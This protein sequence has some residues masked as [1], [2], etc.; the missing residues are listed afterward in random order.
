MVRVLRVRGYHLLISR[1]ILRAKR[2]SIL[3]LRLSIGQGNKNSADNLSRYRPT[4]LRTRNKGSSIQAQ[5]QSK[6]RRITRF[7]QSRRTVKSYMCYQ[8]VT[9]RTIR[10]RSS[11]FSFPCHVQVRHVVTHHCTTLISKQTTASHCQGNVI[12]NGR[13]YAFRAATFASMSLT[14]RVSIIHVFIFQG[15]PFF[16]YFTR[17]NKRFKIILNRPRGTFNMFARALNRLITPFP[18]ENKPKPILLE[19]I[20]QCRRAILIVNIHLRIQSVSSINSL[21][22]P[23]FISQGFKKI[24][25]LSVFPILFRRFKYRTLRNNV[26]ITSNPSVLRSKNVIFTIVANQLNRNRTI[27]EVVNR[28]RTMVMKLRNVIFLRHTTIPF[29]AT[30][31][32]MS[33]PNSKLTRLIFPFTPCAREGTNNDSRIAFMNNVRRCEANVFLR[34]PNFTIR[35]ASLFSTII[36]RSCIFVFNVRLTRNRSDSLILLPI[37]RLLRST[38]PSKKFRIMTITTCFRLLK[39]EAMNISVILFR[40]IRGLARRTNHYNANNSINY[41]RSINKGST[42]VTNAFRCCQFFPRPNDQ[43]NYRSPSKI[44]TSSR[45]IMKQLTRD[46]HANRGRKR[47][48]YFLSRGILFAIWCFLNVANVITLRAINVPTRRLFSSAILITT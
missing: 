14:Q 47:C 30:P 15:S 26:H 17:I 21:N 39:T 16:Y 38:Y 40:S 25:N 22:S 7:F 3:R 41:S 34:L 11:F 37:R 18:Q 6:R 10:V 28:A 2:I 31:V 35:S 48:G 4:E 13:V 43:S 36:T 46:N 5:R 19:R 8:Q 27:H 24:T 9:R 23:P 29:Q 42:C 32:F 1:L 45:R 20:N 12:N 44:T 33:T